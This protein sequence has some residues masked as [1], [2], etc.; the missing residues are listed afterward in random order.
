M[1]RGPW[2]ERGSNHL[3]SATRNCCEIFITPGLF[4][5]FTS[6]P[7]V[8]LEKNMVFYSIF[9]GRC[10]VFFVFGWTLK[11]S[12]DLEKFVVGQKFD[13][14]A[15]MLEVDFALFWSGDIFL[16]HFSY[17]FLRFSEIL[18]LPP[19]QLAP[20]KWRFRG[21]PGAVFAL[22]TLKKTSLNEGVPAGN[23]RNWTYLLC[24]KSNV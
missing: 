2:P 22:Q 5:C 17:I 1:K 20:G 15:T 8:F 21:I 16:A 14:T 13:F 10:E 12:P 11:E 24:F 6:F 19:T 18:D 7:P 4:H 3:A 23:F 9:F